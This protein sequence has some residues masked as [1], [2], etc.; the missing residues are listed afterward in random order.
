[1]KSSWEGIHAIELNN[2][3]PRGCLWLE[4]CPPD[5]LERMPRV[6]QRVAATKRYR[7]AGSRAETRKLADFATLF[8]EDRQPV[9]RC[10]LIPR[11][12]V[13]SIGRSTPRT[14]RGFRRAW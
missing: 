14:S 7:Q 8:G 12:T 6:A 4:G 5:V 1:M 2:H 3:L 11:R 10:V 13:N 9:S